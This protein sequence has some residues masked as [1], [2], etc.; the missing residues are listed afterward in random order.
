MFTMKYS[1]HFVIEKFKQLAENSKHLCFY[2]NFVETVVHTKHAV[3][4]RCFL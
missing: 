1:L 4:D 3:V 2:N